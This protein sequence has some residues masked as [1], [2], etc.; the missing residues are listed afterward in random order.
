M[1]DI[2]DGVTEILD[3]DCDHKE[4]DKAL[5]IGSCC[6]CGKEDKT[7]RN[8]IMLNLKGHVSGAGWG[9]FVCGLP[10][11]GAIAVICD[12]CVE[13]NVKTDE[14]KWVIKGY[15]LEKGMGLRTELTEPFG[16]DM[17]KHQKEQEVG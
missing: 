17:T 8:L 11:D 5:D 10:P 3:G 6:A 12:E 14:I 1:R 7:V 4:I 2:E 13:R 16:H 15:A 9:C